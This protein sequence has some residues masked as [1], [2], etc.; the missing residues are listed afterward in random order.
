MNTETVSKMGYWKQIGKVKQHFELLCDATII[1]SLESNGLLR[2]DWEGRFGD[3]SIH[4]ISGMN[5]E[6]FE[7]KTNRH[8]GRIERMIDGFPKEICL[9]SKTANLGM[10]D[11]SSFAKY[12]VKIKAQGWNSYLTFQGL[13]GRCIATQRRSGKRGHMFDF[14]LNDYATN[15][16]PVGMI[17]I[18]LLFLALFGEPRSM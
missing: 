18:V 15:D 6:I 9:G 3:M 16:P 14:E 1:A 11:N 5:T 10:D 4:I 7:R 13:D 2:S 12:I 17:A 8:L